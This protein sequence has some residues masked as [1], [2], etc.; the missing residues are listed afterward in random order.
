VKVGNSSSIQPY[1]TS[2]IGVFPTGFPYGQLGSYIINQRPTDKN[3]RPEFV[4]TKEEKYIGLFNNRITIDGSAY[5][6][7]TKDLITAATASSASGLATSQSNI[8]DMTTKGIEIDL[9]LVPIK[10]ESFK[11]DLHKLL[12]Q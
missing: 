3:I 6:S 4:T 11:W 7:N 10:T 8:G 12:I 9:G 5:I 1:A 2:E